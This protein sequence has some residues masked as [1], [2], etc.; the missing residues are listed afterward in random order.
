[1]PE[2]T[3]IIFK[4]TIEAIYDILHMKNCQVSGIG[5]IPTTNKIAFS[6]GK[7]DL[8][9]WMNRRDIYPGVL[10]ENLPALTLKTE[11]A[12]YEVPQYN[13][14]FDGTINMDMTE[15]QHFD[16]RF[17]RV[18]Q[19]TIDHDN[20]HFWRFLY[21][22][23]SNEWFL[24]IHALNYKDDFGSTYFRNLILVELDGHKLN[25]FA[26]N[27]D[28]INWMVIESME[29]VTYAEMD[30][31]VLSLIIAMGFVL[32]KR[33][34]DYCFHVQSDCASFAQIDGVEALALQKTKN[35]PFQILDNN[36]HAIEQWLG[37][38][39]YQ[40]YAL[41]GLKKCKEGG[42]T[43]WLYNDE[44]SV[45]MDAFNKLAL[46][47][48]KSNDMM[49]A[50][51]MLIDGSLLNIE[52]QKAFFYVALETITSSL[53]KN[54]SMS[55]PSTM[56][57]ERFSEDVVPVLLDALNGIPNLSEESLR[58]FSQRIEH[59]LNT[60][61]NANKLEA[62]FPKYDYSL[63]DADKDAIK[64]RNKTLHG[65][66]SNEA[67]PLREQQSEMLSINLRL[68]K[69]CSILLLK[70]AGFSG[71]VLNNEVLFGIKEACERKEP[72]YIA[73]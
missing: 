14:Y 15:Q 24:K 28:S 9:F 43:R 42:G 44:A 7:I 48:Y 16:L 69:L 62:C 17:S 6:P 25:I 54:E 46:L 4:P 11:K 73:I 39:D 27:V 71:Q 34:G 32:G 68:H 33:F 45:T 52:Y 21:P 72:V 18:T 12:T 31:R 70:A 22:V 37:A 55:L 10:L 50:A 53:M 67:K 3:N 40:Q 58:V 2:P 5:G 59:N 30:Q 36:I 38:N 63:S 1:M 57:Q 47:C 19:T 20:C 65:S 49:L 66:L 41:E 35:C 8:D 61:P 13:A 29:P 60:A 64:K 26:N 51:S 56:P 23:D